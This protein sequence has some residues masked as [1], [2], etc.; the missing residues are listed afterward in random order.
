MY[1]NTTSLHPS[2]KKMSIRP[3]T[4]T[5]AYAPMPV[6]STVPTTAHNQQRLQQVL[7]AGQAR[8]ALVKPALIQPNH[9]QADTANL[10]EIKKMV[11]RQGRRAV[12]AAK[13]VS[14]GSRTGESKKADA[15]AAA[16]KKAI[17]TRKDYIKLQSYDPK[18]LQLCEKDFE[19]AQ[20]LVFEFDDYDK[21]LEQAG[22]H[23][24]MRSSYVFK[25]LA[26]QLHAALHANLKY[27]KDDEQRIIAYWINVANTMYKDA[28]SADDKLEYYKTWVEGFM[29]IFK[30]HCANF[31]EF[32]ATP[33]PMHSEL[34]KQLYNSHV[35]SFPNN[36]HEYPLDKT[37]W[38]T[39]DETHKLYNL[40]TFILPS[41]VDVKNVEPGAGGPAVANGADKFR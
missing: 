41:E 29:L 27:I 6:S 24:Y 11:Q 4:N 26:K 2:Y 34:V 10:Y 38:T 22:K 5:P 17:E 19:A 23:P 14:G 7:A 12:A 25:P 20:K 36:F 9:D 39:N 33:E 28:K 30:V 35:A 31:C 37:T 13:V 32:D 3:T 16:W 8:T 15:L 40:D 21:T 1:K 18:Y